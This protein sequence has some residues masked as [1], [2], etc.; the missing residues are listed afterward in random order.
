[1][2]F[3]KGQSGNP[4]GRKKGIPEAATAEWVGFLRGVTSS[5][6]YRKS[7][8]QR[9]VNGELPPQLEGKAQDYAYGPPPKPEEH[10][11]SRIQVS[12]GFLTMQPPAV[13]DV[14]VMP[15]TPRVSAPSDLCLPVPGED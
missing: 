5:P 6:A 7:F 2:P 15:S 13:I 8:A 9:L 11:D 14:A 10:H 3:K 1:M 4:A 12:I